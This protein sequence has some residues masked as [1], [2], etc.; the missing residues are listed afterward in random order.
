MKKVAT[1]TPVHPTTEAS[2]WGSGFT[3]DGRLLR[4]TR[5]RSAADREPGDAVLHQ[6]V[7]HRGTVA[8]PRSAIPAS[9]RWTLNARR[10]E[11]VL[12]ARLQLQPRGG[13]LGHAVHAA[14]SPAA[15]PR[16]DPE[17]RRPAAL[18]PGR[19]HA[20]RRHLPGAG[21]PERHGRRPGPAGERGRRP[22]QLPDHEEPGRFTR[23]PGQRG[24]GG[25]RHRHPAHRTRPTCASTTSP[26]RSTRW[27]APPTAGWSRATASAAAR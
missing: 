1:I 14:T 26:R 7:G 11:V 21:R 6:D 10:H 9:A 20:R 2:Q 27:S 12:P 3:H 8:R 18:I 15:P 22:R 16:H 5:R 19:Q 17:R 23:R 4:V 13:T 25:E 24:L